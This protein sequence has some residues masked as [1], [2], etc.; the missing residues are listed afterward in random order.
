MPVIQFN[1]LSEE[2]KNLLYSAPALVTYLIGGA[3]DDFDTKE[4]GRA[5]HLVHIRTTHGDPLL[6]DFYK[7]IE[8]TYFDQ[9]N[10]IVKTYGQLSVE[11]RTAK[12]IS[13][14]EKLNDIL[15]KIDGLYARALI[16]SLKS[17]AK[18]VAETSSGMMGFLGVKYEEE[19]LMGLNMIT[20]QS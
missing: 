9:L 18:L 1:Q 20:Y 11:E 14:L 5:R 10:S 7:H 15:P 19:H 13:E 4:E 12:L 17:L 2:E 16:K 6:F 3:D 8:S